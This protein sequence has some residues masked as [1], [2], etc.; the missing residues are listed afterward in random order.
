MAMHRD[1]V[2]D[3]LADFAGPLG[4]LISHDEQLARQ[5]R[6]VEAGGVELLEALIDLIAS[7]PPAERL[8]N[9]DLDDW[10]VVLVEIAGT[11]GEQYPDAAIQRLVPLL[12][13]PRARS[14]AIDVLGGVGDARAVAPLGR[15]L[16]HRALDADQMIRLAGALGSIGGAPACDLLHQ[17]RAAAP[18]GDGEL[19][20]EIA[21]AL[22]LAGCTARGG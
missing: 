17:L 16:Q 6:W 22:E 7:P 13:Q 19:Q 18:P 15:L 5:D 2:I 12:D 11:L 9:V 21:I 4:P 8:G 3:T 1:H 10:N 20:Q 14:L